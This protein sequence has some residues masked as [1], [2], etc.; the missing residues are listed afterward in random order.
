MNT[1]SAYYVNATTLAAYLVVEG[2]FEVR[3]STSYEVYGGVN[4]DQFSW[5]PYENTVATNAYGLQE[6]RFNL[7]DVTL[8]GTPDHLEPQDEVIN[9]LQLRLNTS[10]L[11]VD[12]YFECT[13][14][15]L[16]SN[17]SSRLK[18]NCYF[19]E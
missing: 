7:S 5:K 4:A 13:L 14:L 12:A 18:N 10:K 16:S 19:K 3:K 6:L 17:E 11:Q 9:R 1:S 8:K 2:M 15:H